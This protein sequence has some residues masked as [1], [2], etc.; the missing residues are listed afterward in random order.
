MT[1]RRLRVKA[2]VVQSIQKHGWLEESN[3][4]HQI[5]G[6]VACQHKHK[7][8]RERG[9]KGKEGKLAAKISRLTDA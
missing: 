8:G 5:E 6:K 9:K 7:E 1:E 3:I 4:D 2:Q